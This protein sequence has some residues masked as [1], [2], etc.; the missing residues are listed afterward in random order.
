MKFCPEKPFEKKLTYRFTYKRAALK[1]KNNEIER[2]VAKRLFSYAFTILYLVKCCSLIVRIFK[3]PYTL[4][5]GSRR[6]NFGIFYSSRP[7]IS[8]ED[9]AVP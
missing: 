2:N 8:A 3:A 9:E 1:K 7:Y 4:S 6:A 5:S